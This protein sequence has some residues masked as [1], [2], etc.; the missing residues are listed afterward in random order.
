MANLSKEQMD[1]VTSIHGPIL[2]VSCPGSGK[3]TVIVNRAN[4]M[5]KSGIPE[6]NILVITFTKE[7]ALQ[8]QRRYEEEFGPTHIFFGTIHSLCFRVLVQAFNYS[9]DDILRATEQWNFFRELLYKKVETKDFE[10]F[11]KTLI[12][13]ISH[14][15]N[16]E[17][18]YKKYSP[19]E[20]DDDLFRDAFYRYEKFKLENGKIDFDDMLIKTRDCFRNQPEVLKLWQ[21]RFPYIMVDEYQ[22]TSSIQADICDLLAG[23]ND[24]ICAV[25][26]DDQS[27]YRFRGAK[28]E[29]ILDFGKK[30][31]NCKIYHLSTNYRSGREI[32]ERAGKLIKNNTKRFKKDF[33]ASNNFNGVIHPI[34]FPSTVA[35]SIGVLREIEKLHKKGVPYDDMSVLYR[36][37]AQN[38]IM[39]GHLMK[40]KIPFYTTEPPR[41]YHNE[42]IF[43]DLMAYWRLSEGVGSK[44]DLKRILNRPGRYLKA[45]CFKG[46]HCNTEE[47]MRAC[48]QAGDKED[49]YQLQILRLLHDIKELKRCKSPKEFTEYLFYRM[50]YARWTLDFAKYIQKDEDQIKQLTKTLI[51]E[52]SQFQSMREWENY[53]RMYAE[54]LEEK[55]KDRKKRGLCLSTFHSAKGLEWRAVFILDANENFAPFKKAETLEDFEEERRLFYVGVTR[56]KELC[57]IA[58]IKSEDDKVSDYLYEMELISKTCGL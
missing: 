58:Y 30:H 43:G 12:G 51:D 11:V 48:K 28:V 6:S 19:D 29:Q 42:F 45:D 49:Q 57:E 16:M 5:V 25:G 47:L 46:C 50:G 9:K 41:D 24:N 31:K 33:L 54:L 22:D 10:E 7:A 40:L 3:T 56:A 14:V 44:M 39:I 38:Q 17:L 34:S 52:G 21:A 2:V 20:I 4:R 23:E 1:I 8:M 55:R 26:D 37:N 36:T 32:V 15:R 13:E 18:D 35:E 27:I 53:A